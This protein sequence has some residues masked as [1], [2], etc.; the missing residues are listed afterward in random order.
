MSDSPVVDWEQ[1]D[2]I[3]DGYAPDFVEIYREFE[4]DLPRI[5]SDLKDAL[6]AGDAMLVSRAAHQ[7]KGS[8]AN[9]GFTEF[10]GV[11]ARIEHQAKAG[12]LDGVDAHLAAA[13]GLFQQSLAAVKSARGI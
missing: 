5:L 11:M 2:M 3:A 7:A 10:S 4:V 8:A 9:F 12:S 13:N 1:L 6:A